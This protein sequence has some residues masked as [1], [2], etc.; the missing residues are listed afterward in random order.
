MTQKTGTWRLYRPT[1][2]G[3]VLHWF[4][5]LSQRSAC[6]GAVRRR[7][8]DTVTPSPDQP[9]R[10]EACLKTTQDRGFGRSKA[11]PA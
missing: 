3:A 2:G 10:C 9:L 4:G 1:T 11:G 7:A 8:G 5:N 6:M